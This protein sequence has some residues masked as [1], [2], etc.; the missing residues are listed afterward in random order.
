M[1]AIL[2]TLAIAVALAVS[3]QGPDRRADEKDDLY[4]L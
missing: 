1:V 3:H 4:D 2:V